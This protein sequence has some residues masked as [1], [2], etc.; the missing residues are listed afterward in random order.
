MDGPD[1][2]FEKGN[3]MAEEMDPIF[4]ESQPPEV[5][6]HVRDYSHFV[7]LIKWGAITCLAIAFILLVFIL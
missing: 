1:Q 4:T 5:A 7:Q 2:E 6:T 3:S